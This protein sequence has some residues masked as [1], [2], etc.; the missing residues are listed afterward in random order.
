MMGIISTVYYLLIPDPTIMWARI[1]LCTNASKFAM[2]DKCKKYPKMSQK[3]EMA[4]HNIKSNQ[5]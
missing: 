2:N 5:C 1:S 3:F 4:L